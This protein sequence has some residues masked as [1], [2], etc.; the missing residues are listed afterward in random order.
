MICQIFYMGVWVDG[1]FS[2][3]ISEVNTKSMIEFCNIFYY[4]FEICWWAMGLIS[5]IPIYPCLGRNFHVDFSITSDG[6]FLGVVDFGLPVGL[7]N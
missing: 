5:S 6:V 4:M 3:K 1:F 7:A 2:F